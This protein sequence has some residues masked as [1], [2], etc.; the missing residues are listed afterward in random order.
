MTSSP[1]SVHTS[2]PTQTATAAS[3]APGHLSISEAAPTASS[4]TVTATSS[5]SNVAPEVEQAPA[6]AGS[7]WLATLRGIAR[8]PASIRPTVPIPSGIE[9]SA[10]T[11]IRASSEVS[12]ASPNEASDGVNTEELAHLKP[13]QLTSRSSAGTLRPTQAPDERDGIQV[14]GQPEANPEASSAILASPTALITGLSDRAVVGTSNTGDPRDANTLRINTLAAQHGAGVGAGWTGHSPAGWLAWLTTTPSSSTHSISP[15]RSRRQIGMGEEDLVMYVDSDSDGEGQTAVIPRGRLGKGRE[16]DGE[17]EETDVDAMTEDVG[18][19]PVMT[20]STVDSTFEERRA[21]VTG[22]S[23]GRGRD[24]AH[25]G[26]QKENSTGKGK[27]AEKR[28]GI[29]A[30]A[31]SLDSVVSV[32][33]EGE[34]EGER[35]GTERNSKSR[36][37]STIYS[38]W[39]FFL[40]LHFVV[41]SWTHD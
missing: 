7:N 26:Q 25:A 39:I 35:E 29:C 22:W 1:L 5:V 41:F 13:P 38:P 36:F 20:P 11:T 2:T 16:G 21:G 24:T 6:P 10:N 4:S 31:L 32:L 12:T 8:S 9:T 18:P 19:T 23:W 14:S 33:S 40:F 37:I 30:T 17:G 27:I 34:G 28:P 15:T 3:P